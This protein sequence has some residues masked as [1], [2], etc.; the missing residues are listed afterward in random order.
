MTIMEGREHTITH[1]RIAWEVFR[2]AHVRAF[3][4]LAGRRGDRSLGAAQVSATRRALP[5]PK[6][7]CVKNI[8]N[9]NF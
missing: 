7:K 3:W 1:G 9:M 8:L 5:P 4:F 6:T 2:A